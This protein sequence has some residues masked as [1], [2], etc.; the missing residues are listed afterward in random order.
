MEQQHATETQN[1]NSQETNVIPLHDP[2]RRTKRVLQLND[3]EILALRDLLN[4][5]AHAR[6]EFEQIKTH[7]PLAARALSTR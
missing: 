3:E 4:Y 2:A 1:A 6:E 5:A 7:C